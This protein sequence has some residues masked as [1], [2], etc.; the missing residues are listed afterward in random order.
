MAM[1]MTQKILAAHAGLDKVEAGQLIGAY[2]AQKLGT[3][4]HSPMDGRV[5]EV[6]DSYVIIEK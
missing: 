3:S 6:T 1:T 2:D 5:K 4:V